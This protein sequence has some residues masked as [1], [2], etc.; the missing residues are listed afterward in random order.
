MILDRIGHQF[1]PQ[2]ATRAP[3]PRRSLATLHPQVYFASS[4]AL[5][6][7]GRLLRWVETFA[8]LW[9]G[10]HIVGFVSFFGWT[11]YTES[12]LLKNDSALLKSDEQA[13]QKRQK[14]ER[15]RQRQ[16]ESK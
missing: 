11:L 10:G 5:Y 7:A 3:A 9:L 1:D 14:D 16:E 12:D 8:P 15:R 4:M 13:E 2:R 6:P